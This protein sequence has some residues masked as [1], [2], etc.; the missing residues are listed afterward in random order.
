MTNL[1][2]QL[3]Y[4]KDNPEEFA[5]RLCKLSC[6]HCSVGCKLYCRDTNKGDKGC[7]DTILE[8]L[9]RE[10]PSPMSGKPY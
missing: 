6:E 9:L 2:A 7:A 1:D 10:S 3:K 8:W 4:F 5:D